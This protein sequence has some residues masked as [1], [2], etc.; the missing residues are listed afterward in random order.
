MKLLRGQRRERAGFTLVEVMVS[1]CVAGVILGGLV[2]G[3]VALQ[4]VVSAA[5]EYTRASADQLR[6]L[7][8]VARD[9]RRATTVTTSA[10]GKTLT[11][12]LPDYVDMTVNTSGNPPG[13]QRIP[14]ITPGSQTPVQYGV[15]PSYTPITVSYFMTGQSVIRQTGGTQSVI[16]NDPENFQFSCSPAGATNPTQVTTSL[17]F[18]PRFS[19]LSA[20]GAAGG[21]AISTTIRRN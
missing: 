3:T 9:V 4:T 2:L 6:V 13:L 18:T 11:V 16:S 1:A 5:D 15:G 20:A 7:D 19:R 8:Y 10:D 17:S 21:T 12:T 14:L